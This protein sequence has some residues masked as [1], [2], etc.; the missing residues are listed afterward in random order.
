MQEPL[1]LVREDMAAIKRRTPKV[2]LQ[3]LQT[4]KIGYK[5]LGFPKMY[6]I[7]AAVITYI[8]CLTPY[9]IVGLYRKLQKNAAIKREKR[10]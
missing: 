5:M 2:R 6:Y 8:K 7:K 3:T 9:W 4:T 1:Y 10:K